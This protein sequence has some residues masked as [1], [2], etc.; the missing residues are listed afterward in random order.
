MNFYIFSC[1]HILGLK[2]LETFNEASLT[3]YLVCDI[4][5]LVHS[6]NVYQNIIIMQNNFTYK[7]LLQFLI[8]SPEGDTK[9]YLSNNSVGCLYVSGSLITYSVRS[10]NTFSYSTLDH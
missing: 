8:K 9:F 10:P 1:N 4:C 7:T 3:G 5:R 6:K 2:E